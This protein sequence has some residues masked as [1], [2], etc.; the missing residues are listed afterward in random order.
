MNNALIY[1]FLPENRFDPDS[2]KFI[3]NLQYQT[4]NINSYYLN[5]S[6]SME[7]T[8]YADHVQV[9]DDTVN[10]F[11]RKAPLTRFEGIA[12][13]PNT[14]YPLSRMLNSSSL[15]YEV[16]IRPSSLE[17]NYLIT[18]PKADTILG[19][20]GGVIVLW[21][22]I[23]HWLG[24]AFNNF[25]V[26]AAQA[27]AI[28]A[29]ETLD[30]NVLMKLLALSPL[31][32]CVFP[33]CLDIKNTITR[34]RQVDKKIVNDLNYLWLVKYVNNIFELSSTLF[35]RRQEQNLSKVFIKEKIDESSNVIPQAEVKLRV[36]DDELI[37]LE[38]FHDK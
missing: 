31:P 27:D 15:Y 23:C 38:D 16:K 22:A 17:I 7:E 10:F 2:Q 1:L 12:I 36:K 4:L 14:P 18:S 30:E 33:T 9:Q 21:Y 24:K 11:M 19:I 26:R 5:Q 37:D 34:M 29:E 13:N 28:Y 6:A 32:L 35:N 3:N 20:I 8:V 25:Q